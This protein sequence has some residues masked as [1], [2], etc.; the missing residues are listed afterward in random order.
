MRRDSSFTA[1]AAHE[2]LPSPPH[3]SNIV[4]EEALAALAVA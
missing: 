2:F 3:S 4:R 1:M